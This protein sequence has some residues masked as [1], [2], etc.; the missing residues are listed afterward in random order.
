MRALFP[1]VCFTWNLWRRV[2]SWHWA[3]LGPF[4]VERRLSESCSR[5]FSRPH[6]ISVFHVEQ[7]V[8]EGQS[9]DL[10]WLGGVEGGFHVEHPAAEELDSSPEKVWE[11]VRT[12]RI[13]PIRVPWLKRSSRW[14]G[15]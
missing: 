1:R 14:N 3:E 11:R 7:R 5:C 10:L 13:C 12:C 4:H 8:T 2:R 15:R 9:Q 6:L